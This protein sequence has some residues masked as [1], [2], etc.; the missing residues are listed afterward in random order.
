MPATSR[1]DSVSIS[2][3]CRYMSLFIL[4][5]LTCMRFYC[6]AVV[7]ECVLLNFACYCILIRFSICRMILKSVASYSYVELR[8]NN[9]L[10]YEEQSRMRSRS[11][12]QMSVDYFRSIDCKPPVMLQMWGPLWVRNIWYRNNHK[13]EL[14]Q[15][16]TLL[17]VYMTSWSGPRDTLGYISPVPATFKF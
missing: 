16:P 11:R 3:E 17:A 6:K 9:L 4:L 8:G 2:A 14:P 12:W 7:P 13:Y 10:E 5:V 15:S 1:V